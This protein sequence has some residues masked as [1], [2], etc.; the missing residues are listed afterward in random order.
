MS[1]INGWSS[2]KETP[3]AKPEA[4][5]AAFVSE[6]RKNQPKKPTK[7]S[8]APAI[9]QPQGAVQVTPPQTDEVEMALDDIEK[10]VAE[11]KQQARQMGTEIDYH[12]HLL[13]RINTR[14]EN[15]NVRVRKD[16]DM[17][18]RLT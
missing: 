10:V 9:S 11:L 1:W 3:K 5:R 6:N 7:A 17:I 8:S 13:D 14:V 18:V 2:P 15:T 4:L 16:N 12:N